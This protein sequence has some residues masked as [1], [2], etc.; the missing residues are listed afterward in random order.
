MLYEMETGDWI[1]TDLIISIGVIKRSRE[2]QAFYIKCKFSK[3]PLK[4][5]N[6]TGAVESADGQTWQYIAI[7]LTET[8]DNLI[9]A[10]KNDK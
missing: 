6:V 5:S 1:D 4:I 2:V 9:R 8:R 7:D 3:E 10:W